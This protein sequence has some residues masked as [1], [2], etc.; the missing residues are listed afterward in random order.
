MNRIQELEQQMK[1]IL[2][3]AVYDCALDESGQKVNRCS[4]CM[5][6]MGIKV[7][8]KVLCFKELESEQ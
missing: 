8:N 5:S 2:K 3:N 7:G 4:Q 1:E 6:N